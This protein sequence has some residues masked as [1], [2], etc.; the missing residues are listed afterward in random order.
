[1]QSCHANIV[2]SYIDNITY[3]AEELQFVNDVFKYLYKGSVSSFAKE[4]RV[5]QVNWS[6]FLLGKRM[7]PSNMR[8]FK[9]LVNDHIG[10]HAL[11]QTRCTVLQ[12]M[13]NLLGEVNELEQVTIEPIPFSL[14][15]Q[16][17]TDGIKV[18]IFVDGDQVHHVPNLTAMFKNGVE[19]VHCVIVRAHSDVTTI[20]MTVEECK[21]TT[22]IASRFGYSESTDHV[23]SI[24][25]ALYMVKNSI[26]YYICSDDNFAQTLVA[27]IGGN[28]HIIRIREGDTLMANLALSVYQDNADALTRSFQEYAKAILDG[29]ERYKDYHLARYLI[30]NDIYV[31]PPGIR[32]LA[33]MRAIQHHIREGD[34]I[35]PSIPLLHKYRQLL[36]AIDL[37]VEIQSMSAPLDEE[38]ARFF[39]VD[40]FEILLRTPDVCVLLG[41]MAYGQKIYPRVYMHH[42]GNALTESALR[43]MVREKMERMN[44]HSRVISRKHQASSVTFALWL[45]LGQPD[46]ETI[47]DK[48]YQENIYSVLLSAVNYINE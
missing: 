17:P 25:L 3:T 27:N 18:I 46:F 14:S 15:I 20:T 19:G 11:P 6:L 16:L 42:H 37:P 8:A 12:Y 9:Q 22:H 24:L 36:N 2:L 38:T 26:K 45:R 35:W 30:L 28:G 21:Y 43:K 10:V 44:H 32:R 5:D 48:N 29:L 31:L 7:N 40:R 23:I 33:A 34:K 47:N 39:G 13:Y 1:M 4:Y 41:V